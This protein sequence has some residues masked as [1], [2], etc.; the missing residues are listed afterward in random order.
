MAAP[1]NTATFAQLREELAEF[2]TRE[3]ELA[4]A[5]LVP[6]AKH[7]GIG[8]GL[9]AGAGIFALHALWMLILCGAL[10]IGWLLASLTLL[11]PWGAFTI[12]FATA[13][14]ISL[15]IAFVLIKVG[16]G[17]LRKVK[18][19]SATIAEAGA[20]F[21]ALL[22]AATGKRPDAELVVRPTPEVV[23]T[24]RRSA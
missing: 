14:I 5:E 19:P 17:Q 18:A 24:P 10:G 9:F 16:Q 20:T 1:D 11:S 12:G 3:K 15:L 22:D 2:V 8:S 23:A 21:S 13:A 4:K 7:A 6:A